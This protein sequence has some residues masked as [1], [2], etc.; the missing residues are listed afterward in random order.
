MEASL[1]RQGWL[2]HWPLPIKSSAP[3]P[4]GGGGGGG[5]GGAGLCVP[6]SSYLVGWLSLALILWLSRGFPNSPHRHELRCGHQGLPVNSKRHLQL[7][8]HLGNGKSFKNSVPGLGMKTK[9]VILTIN[10]NM[11]FPLTH[12]VPSRCHLFPEAFSSHSRDA[13]FPSH[14]AHIR[15]R[16]SVFSRAA[17]E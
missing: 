4:R 10:Y 2:N 16:L 7:S 12:K 6:T 11:S 1:C 17:P 8:Y 9:H 13:A 15:F 3:P 14:E 5:G